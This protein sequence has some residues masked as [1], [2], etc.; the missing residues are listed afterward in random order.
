[1]Y[2]YPPLFRGAGVSEDSAED[3]AMTVKLQSGQ[4]DQN[5]EGNEEERRKTRRYSSAAC[6]LYAFT[7][8]F[9]WPN[10][11]SSVLLPCSACWLHTV[12]LLM[13]LV[14]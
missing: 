11:S 13:P 2:G 6:L 7:L 1:M 12:T 3:V 14:I 9:D 5:Y 10:R 8:L 4:E